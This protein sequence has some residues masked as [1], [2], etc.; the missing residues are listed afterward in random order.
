[1]YYQGEE[2]IKEILDEKMLSNLELN[3]INDD[4]SIKEKKETTEGLDEIIEKFINRYINLDNKR[5]DGKELYELI[6]N[7]SKNNKISLERNVVGN[8]FYLENLFIN[9]EFAK[10]ADDKF[11]VEELEDNLRDEKNKNE[12]I[13]LT[14]NFNNLKLKIDKI[15]ELLSI[16]KNIENQVIDGRTK[17]SRKRITELM[18]EKIKSISEDISKLNFETSF[19][20]IIEI[21]NKI[22]NIYKSIYIYFKYIVT[23]ITKDDEE[24]NK[25]KEIL[26]NMKIDLKAEFEL[27]YNYKKSKE[28]INKYEYLLLIKEY[29]KDNNIK[30]KNELKEKNFFVFKYLEKIIKNLENNESLKS[31][32]C[33]GNMDVYIKNVNREL[34][35]DFFDVSLDLKNIEE[36]KNNKDKF[37]LEIL[38]LES[39][40]IALAELYLKIN[41][42]KFNSQNNYINIIE[43]KELNR[44]KRFLD[45]DLKKGLI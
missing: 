43:N 20:D 35:G 7:F 13:V 37:N 15:N 6:L 41:K 8:L 16:L 3:K 25:Y 45:A 21:Y 33:E 18:S 19:S 44:I 17:K 42:D 9:N 32:Y 40:K 31:D 38:N 5:I 10:K 27:F 4:D 11:K 26:T 2:K 22:E 1:M 14:L 28:Q 23:V 34:E 30:F 39:K 12:Q 24:L 29:F 36:E